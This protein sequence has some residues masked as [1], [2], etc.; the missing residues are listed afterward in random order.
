M[1][2][3]KTSDE[4]AAATLSGTE[5]VRIVQGGINVRCTTQQIA[6]LGVAGTGGG[7]G[8]V[9]ALIFGA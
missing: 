1:S 8:L 4:S 9:F 7:D 3:V 2:D 5:L 6:D